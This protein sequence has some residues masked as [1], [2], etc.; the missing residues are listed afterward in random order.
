V[1]F[2]CA[3]ARACPLAEA[4]ADLVLLADVV[5][6]VADWRAALGEAARLL[7]PGGV[8]YVNTI[9]RTARARWLA[10]HVAEGLR[11]LPRGT[12]DA[13]MFV[14]PEELSAAAAAVGL[15][16]TASAGDAAGMGDQSATEP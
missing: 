7:R 4:S 9:N 3:D 2:T 10:V 15:R 13:A 14:R 11:L 8:L 6:H 16:C 5:E 12:H 1:Y